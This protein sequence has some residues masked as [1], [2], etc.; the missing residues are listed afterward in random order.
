MSAVLL[1][2]LKNQF[3]TLQIKYVNDCICVKMQQG[4]WH[5]LTTNDSS[6]KLVINE[7]AVKRTENYVIF[8]QIES[9]L[10]EKDPT[11]Y[12]GAYLVIDNEESRFVHFTKDSAFKSRKHINS[13]GKI[14]LGDCKEE[15]LVLSE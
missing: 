8:K 6:N 5:N 12:R 1:G 13:Y 4:Y 10:I 2:Q 15:I 11:F 3:P 7:E 9:N 14:G